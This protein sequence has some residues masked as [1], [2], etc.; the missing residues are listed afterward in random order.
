MGEISYHNAY[1][2]WGEGIATEAAARVTEFGLKDLG[3]RRI[4]GQVH[5]ENG[6]SIRVLEKNE[7]W[8]EGLLRHYPFG[9]E[10]HD[11]VMLAIVPAACEQADGRRQERYGD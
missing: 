2:S 8:R 3:L 9:R 7:Y 4:Q 5:A 6:A 11:V 1:A 10:F